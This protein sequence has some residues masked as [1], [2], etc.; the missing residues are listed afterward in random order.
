MANERD[1]YNKYNGFGSLIHSSCGNINLNNSGS[2]MIESIND[3]PVISLLSLRDDIDDG[4]LVF[5]LRLRNADSRNNQAIGV[6]LNYADSLNYTELRFINDNTDKFEPHDRRYT[7]IE[8]WN[9]QNGVP[10]R[11]ATS[12]KIF[13]NI[14]H[15]NEFKTICLNFICGDLIVQAG[16]SSFGTVLQMPFSLDVTKMIGVSSRGKVELKNLYIDY[17]P[18]TLPERNRIL[19]DTEIDD[20]LSASNDPIVGFWNYFDRKLNS[21]K[22]LLGGKYTLAVLPDNDSNEFVIVSISD[23]KVNDSKWIKGMIKGRLIP[24]GVYGNYNLIWY[25]ADMN[26]MSDDC[27]ALLSGSEFLEFIFPIEKSSFRLIKAK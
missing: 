12:E 19:S 4:N 2:L 24:T 1:Y 23:A 21:P 22:V 16:R 3:V 13:K 18:L 5:A 7:I 15:D 17:K 11:T 10:V 26:E 20:M 14:G 25:D 8:V 27:Y 6:I 9:I